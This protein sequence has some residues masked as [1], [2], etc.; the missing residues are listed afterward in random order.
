MKIVMLLLSL[1]LYT[2]A[3]N[4]PFEKDSKDLNF[5][6]NSFDIFSDKN[7]KSYTKLDL[8]STENSSDDIECFSLDTDKF[9]YICE[10]TQFD[11]ILEKEYKTIYAFN[12]IKNSIS[13]VVINS[14]TQD[15]I[16]KLFNC[17]N[18]DCFDSKFYMKIHKKNHG[19]VKASIRDWKLLNPKPIIKILDENNKEILSL[20]AS[21][22]LAKLKNGFYTAIT[23]INSKKFTQVLMI[24]DD[25]IEIN[26]DKIEDS[27]SL[28]KKASKIEKTPEALQISYGEDSSISGVKKYLKNNLDN[29]NSYKSIKWGETTKKGRF[30]MIEHE[31]KS[32]NSFGESSINNQIFTLDSKHR[33]LFVVDNEY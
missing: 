29:F 14:A 28:A 32:K 33:V 15:K 30:Y 11:E 16:D 6:N 8:K 25:Y 18:R 1:S 4:Y 31:Y 7:S 2:L 24:D 27:K 26:F 20:T 23:I 10:Y 17:S 12:F 5:L 22:N 21:K 13:G 3:F 9:S 19:F